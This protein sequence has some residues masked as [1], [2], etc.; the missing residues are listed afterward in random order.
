LV[1]TVGGDHSI[2][3]ATVHGSMSRNPNLKVIWVDAHPDFCNPDAKDFFYQNY[4]GASLSHIA[5]AY[6]LPGF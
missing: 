3:S 1:L 5:G 2:G 6:K 4:H